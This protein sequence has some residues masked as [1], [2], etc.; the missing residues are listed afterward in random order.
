[1]LNIVEYKEYGYIKLKVKDVM[2]NKDVNVY[3]VS[4][5]MGVH[6]QTIQNLY[7]S[8]TV[9]R[10]DFRLLAKLCYVLECKTEDLIE[11]VAP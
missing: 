2:D 10:L 3:N 1:M 6:F 7:N 9:T 11:Y 5:S 8:E 4:E